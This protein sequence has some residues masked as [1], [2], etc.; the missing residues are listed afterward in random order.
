MRA[1][2]FLFCILGFAFASEITTPYKQIEASAN[3]LSTTLINGKL[4]VATD[5]GT[6]EIYNP[7]EDKFEEII[8]IDDIKTYV[9][10]HERPKILSVDE[11]DGRTLILSEGD[12]ATKVLYLRENGEMKS[13]KLSN[14]A[15]KKALFLDDEH[16]VLASI[17]NEIYFLNIKSG[18]IYENFKIS[19]AM[20]SDM[21]LSEDRN[22]LAIGCESGKVYL[23]NI[24]TKK[25]DQVLDIHT[26]NIYD[27]AYKNN[28][29]ITG[30]TD[31]IA[32]IFSAGSLKKINTGFLVYGV[33]LSDDGKIAAYMS[34]EMSDVNLVDSV[35]LEKIAML[36]TGQSTINSIVF[37]GDNEV[38]TSAYEKKILFWR[39]R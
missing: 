29:L 22:T 3:V 2:F 37:I 7:K 21:E 17:S 30:S 36:K 16:I 31:R 20:L 27:I 11:L 5:G 19:I 26:D 1:L 35:S 6:V 32:G 24:K 18:E 28:V 8:K 4:F 38:V 39:V 13:I 12:Y 25:M 15:I 10:E 34:D 14:Q 9:S 33:G 23:Y